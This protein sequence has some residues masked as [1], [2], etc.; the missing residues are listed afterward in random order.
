MNPD[1]P[2]DPWLGLMS[3]MANCPSIHAWRHRV[4]V[5]EYLMMDIHPDHD[6]IRR[7]VDSQERRARDTA[8]ALVRTQELSGAATVPDI[9]WPP[10][11]GTMIVMGCPAGTYPG[12]GDEPSSE[13]EEEEELD[14]GAVP[15]PPPYCRPFGRGRRGGRRG[16]GGRGRGRGG[17]GAALSY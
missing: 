3:Q 5:M 1:V 6:H 17:R 4:R 10:R 16:P 13:S 14:Y 12:I 11:D 2:A 9:S 8:R 7:V 15:P